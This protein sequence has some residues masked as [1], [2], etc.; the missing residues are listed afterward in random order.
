[1]PLL[2]HV[3]RTFIGRGAGRGGGGA[4]YEL[5]KCLKTFSLTVR[6][7]SVCPS[8]W[9]QQLRL[10]VAYSFKIVPIKP[11][12]YSAV[13]I[14]RQSD[15]FYERPTKNVRMPDQMS[16][17]KWFLKSA[18]R[19]SVTYYYDKVRNTLYFVPWHLG[20]KIGVYHWPQCKHKNRFYKS[21]SRLS[22][23]TTGNRCRNRWTMQ[24]VTNRNYHL[25]DPHKFGTWD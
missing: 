17:R 11:S 6:L 16:D 25:R 15:I 22:K 20:D 9:R 13:E 4:V 7:L 10:A 14:R 5:A 8:V 24:N 1:M 21:H 2:V 23:I 18:W 19:H 12:F 3:L